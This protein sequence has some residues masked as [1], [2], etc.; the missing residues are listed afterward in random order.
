M[1]SW[2]PHPFSQRKH[3]RTGECCRFCHL[4]TGPEACLVWWL[5]LDSCVRAS[6]LPHTGGGRNEV[7]HVL[8]TWLWTTALPA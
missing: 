7:T 3:Y 4:D 5:G 1:L 8:A 6:L 2:E